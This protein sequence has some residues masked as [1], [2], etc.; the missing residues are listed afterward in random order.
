MLFLLSDLGV[1]SVAAWVRLG[2]A[3]PQSTNQGPTARL[4]AAPA[5]GTAPF[6]VAFDGSTSSD[7]D[8]GD[9]LSYAWDLDGDGQFD[10]A[11]TPTASFTYSTAGKVVARLQV[12][13]SHGA[14]DET[15]I[16]ITIAPGGGFGPDLIQT[17]AGNPPAS[18]AAGGK[19]A[20]ADAVKNQGTSP[21]GASLTRY[22]LSPDQTRDGGDLRLTGSRAVPSLPPNGVS[23]TNWISLTVPPTAPGGLFYVLAC[24][25]D[26]GAVNET[27]ETN[28]C[29]SSG[30]RVTVL[31]PDLTVTSVT[32]PAVGVRGQNIGV[33]DSTKNI[34]G[35][36]AG[37]SITRYYLSTT[38]GVAG[39][40]LLAQYRTL[41][42]L[43]AGAT[44]SAT[45]SAKVPTTLTPGAYHLIA[46]ADDTGLLSEASE[47]NNCL[48]SPGTMEVR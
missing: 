15:D 11:T 30:N 33:K 16:L 14:S 23:S 5:S 13:D 44:S 41:W 38:T 39:A 18:V 24:A 8:A 40:A 43:G 20:F 34:G 28:N 35:A 2:A 25:D 22:Y 32:H 21:A 4:T 47:A 3:N 12:V 17:S 10:D 42:S 45:L 27:S 36:S 19:F 46:C 9:A 48:A 7:P 6:T 1:P 26:G 31:L 29:R 37:K